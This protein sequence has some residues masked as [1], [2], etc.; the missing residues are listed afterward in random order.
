MSYTI[1]NILNV[2]LLFGLA[3][4]V[5]AQTDEH[6]QLLINNYKGLAIVVIL[7]L[8]SALWNLVGVMASIIVPD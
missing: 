8:V 7:L 1:M 5:N 2:M 4:L 3:I 6:G